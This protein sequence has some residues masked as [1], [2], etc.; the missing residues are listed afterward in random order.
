[1]TLSEDLES[2][3]SSK[4]YQ[5]RDRIGNSVE[6]LKEVKEAVGI[7]VT[8]VFEKRKLELSQQALSYITSNYFKKC[9]INGKN[10]NDLIVANDYTLNEM[11]YNDI[12]IMNNVLN[13]SFLGPAL[14]AEYVKRNVS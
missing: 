4:L 6:L 8:G 11:S 9:A 12:K 1:M 10:V 7:A 5:F 14:E 3:V 2:K 13:D